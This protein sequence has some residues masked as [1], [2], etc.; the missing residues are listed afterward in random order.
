EDAGGAVSWVI[1]VRGVLVAEPKR[2]PGTIGTLAIGEI[3]IAH[4]P[5]VHIVRVVHGQEWAPEHF[6]IGFRAPDRNRTD[7]MGS[8]IRGAAIKGQSPPTSAK[9]RPTTA[10]VL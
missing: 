8:Q 1:V 7:G 2:E 3:Q 9:G 10:I 6:A 5:C 4:Q